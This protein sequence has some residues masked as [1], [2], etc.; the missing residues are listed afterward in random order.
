MEGGSRWEGKKVVVH[1]AKLPRYLDNFSLTAAAG[2][3]QSKRGES[4][5]SFKPE[6]S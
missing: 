5:F 2:L 6:Q 1:L 3:L 4:D